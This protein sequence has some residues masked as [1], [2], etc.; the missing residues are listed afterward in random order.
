MGTKPSFRV[1]DIPP[2]STAEQ[3]QALLNGVSDEGY[4]LQSLGPTRAVFKLPAK[5]VGGQWV[6]E[7]V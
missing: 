5:R 1:L 6:I 3:V 7:N 2:D 4:S